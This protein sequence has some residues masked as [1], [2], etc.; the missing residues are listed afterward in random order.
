MLAD[1]PRGAALAERLALAGAETVVVRP[2]ECFGQDDNG[3]FFVRP[4]EA[5]D[6]AE[7]LGSM[8]VAP[9]TRVAS[10]ALQHAVGWP[11]VIAAVAGWV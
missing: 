11:R 3:D 8:L 2:G 9:R 1:D 5:D 6:F 10:A 4:D 7:V